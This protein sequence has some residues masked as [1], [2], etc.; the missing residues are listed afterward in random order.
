MDDVEHIPNVRVPRQFEAFYRQEYAVVLAL[1]YVLSGS[2]PAAED[3]TQ[4]AFLRAHR[5]WHS[6]GGMAAPEAW[7]RRVAINLS[8]SRFRRLQSEATAH[9]RL[10]PDMTMGVAQGSEY[11]AFWAEVRRLP[12]RQGQAIALFYVEDLSVAEIAEILEIAGGTVKAL[13]HQGRERLER[14]FQAKGWANE[15]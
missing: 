9:L 10:R 3:L 14:Q 4:E 1:I 11:E 15:L 6:V 2:R 7:V 8:R 13:L 5:D 12:R